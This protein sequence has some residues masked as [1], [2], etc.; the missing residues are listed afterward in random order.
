MTNVTHGLQGGVIHPVAAITWSSVVGPWAGRS[1]QG[2]RY[3]LTD[4]THHPPKWEVE[5]A[6]R[7]TPTV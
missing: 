4:T 6:L 2:L 7:M 1:M 5:G 3:F